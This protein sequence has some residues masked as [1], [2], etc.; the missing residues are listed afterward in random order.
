MGKIKDII[1]DGSQVI[2][3]LGY[4]VKLFQFAWVGD[5]VFQQPGESDDGVQWCPQFMAHIAEKVAFGD[6]GCFRL[7]G[8]LLQSDIKRLDLPGALFEF[9]GPFPDAILKF[10]VHPFKFKFV[11]LQGN[12]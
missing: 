11:S 10:G 1:D 6:I 7:N 5:L 8:A 2:G 12:V 3:G 4:S 9:V